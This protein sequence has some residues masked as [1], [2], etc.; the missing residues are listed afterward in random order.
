MR[1]ESESDSYTELSDSRDR[2]QEGA[3][4]ETCIA[5]SV[6]ITSTIDMFSKPSP[7]M[8]DSFFKFHPKL[9]PINIPFQIKSAFHRTTATGTHLQREWLTTT[10]KSAYF[11]V[12][13]LPTAVL[14]MFFRAD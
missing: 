8:L 14:Q 7:L 10:S 13:V 3:L 5:D 2:E 12:F 11:A 4:R 9:P 6:A 1:I